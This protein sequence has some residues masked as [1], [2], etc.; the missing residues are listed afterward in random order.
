MV[1]LPVVMPVTTPVLLTEAMV[2][3]LLIHDPPVVVLL[4]VMELPVHTVVG[5]VMVP[6]EAGVP[7]LTMWAAESVPQLLV[8]T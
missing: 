8:T 6:A 3:L 1:T 4:R 5:P 7:T 2:L